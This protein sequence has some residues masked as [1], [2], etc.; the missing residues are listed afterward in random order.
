MSINF[1]ELDYRRTHL[2]ELILRRRRVPS[3]GG[4]EV[5][6]VKLGD[7]F[8][9]SS[10]FNTGEIA[11]AELGLA[12][13][14]TAQ[15]DVV[16]GGLGLGYTARAALDHPTV[17]SVLVI[18]AL[19]EV[20]DWHQRELV[21]L[22]VKLTADQ[23]C[24]LI[25]GD[26]FALVNSPGQGFDP[27]TPGRRFH[28]ILLDIDHS[29]RNLLHPGHGA[30]YEPTGLRHL[31][32]YLH[33]GGVFALWSNDPPD[34]DFLEALNSIF[35]ASQAHVVTFHNPLMNCEA[36]STVYVARTATADA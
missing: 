7:A 35:A 19:A 2:G 8:L 23:R 10:L 31:T 30:F 1:E 34:D 11:L 4:R 18:E 36:A 13:L 16:V 15:L 24:R 20:I 33:P 28:A 6:E 22:G 27:Q 26:F 9:M 3:L 12:G 14:D 29:P 32:T 5:F 25:N 17:R 21:P